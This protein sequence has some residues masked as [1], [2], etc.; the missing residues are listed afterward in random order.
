MGVTLNEVGLDIE[1]DC[2]SR[3]TGAARVREPSRARVLGVVA[4]LA[5][6]NTG[7]LWLA[8]TLDAQE[9]GLAWLLV[10]IPGAIVSILLIGSTGEWLVH[11]YVMHRPWR[12]RLLQVVYQL[13]HRGHHFVHFTPDRYVHQ[14][15]INYIPVYPPQPEKLCTTRASRFL[16][17]GAQGMFYLVIA[18]VSVF[19][20]TWLATRNLVF[21][22][23]VA[24][25]GVV[26]CYL[27]VR[28]HDLVHYP[29]HSVMERFRWFRYLDHHHYIHH[30]DT[31]ANTNFLLPLGDVLFGTYRDT[32][33]SQ[34]SARW[35]SFE[36]AR[37]NLIRDEPA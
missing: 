10:S 6:G 25:G 22:A 9:H 24:A 7:L 35:P 36:A 32:I 12:S 19:V 16:S 26:E 28:F 8:R 15:E 18:T 13:H 30:L 11:R 27:F 34:E 31:R 5:L 14:G 33:T 4:L 29:G 37:V 21:T 20:P 1:T 2:S 23:V 3:H 17:A